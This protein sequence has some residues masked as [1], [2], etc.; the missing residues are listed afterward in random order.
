MVTQILTSDRI[1]VQKFLLRWCF[2]IFIFKN[3]KRNIIKLSFDFGF[4]LAFGCIKVSFL[5]NVSC[6]S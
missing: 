3:F 2:D 6:E 5:S 1:I 4:G